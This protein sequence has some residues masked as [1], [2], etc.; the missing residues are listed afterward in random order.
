M[1]NNLVG[2]LVSG[3]KGYIGGV[4][5][6]KE[7]QDVARRRAREEE[8]FTWL[9]EDQGS[10]RKLRPIVEETAKI[11]FDIAKRNQADKELLDG[12]FPF[13]MGGEFDHASDLMFSRDPTRFPK[14][15]VKLDPS[16]NLYS[17][18]SGDK[19]LG[20][21]MQREQVQNMF[22]HAL[23][24]GKQDVPKLAGDATGG[25]GS[26][27]KEP[28]FW[29]VALNTAKAKMG[30]IDTKRT[31]AME[32]L[33]A[34]RAQRQGEK[35]YNP[36]KRSQEQI[37]ADN[38]MLNL[39]ETL[40]GLEDESTTLSNWLTFLFV[41]TGGRGVDDPGLANAL[42]FTLKPRGTPG[43]TKNTAD[44]ALDGLRG[45]NKRAL[46]P[47]DAGMKV[48]I[49]SFLRPYLDKLLKSGNLNSVYDTALDKAKS[50]SPLNPEEQAALVYMAITK[51]QTREAEAKEKEAARR[52]S[53]K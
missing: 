53:V 42:D 8:E 14:L 43:N 3:G 33:N 9:Q 13:V 25:G 46:P 12:V 30:A 34:L 16:T 38:E 28:E 35:N 51:A 6:A 36:D 5:Q 31:A 48:E 50:K 22:F 40:R 20:K 52:A 11:N 10:K 2:A 21:N 39:E 45:D 17:V 4:N 27:S 44:D 15:Q 29:N 32:R 23:N 7:E 41:Q 24:P 47:P 19:L 37:D 1:F 49:S 26:G 18:V